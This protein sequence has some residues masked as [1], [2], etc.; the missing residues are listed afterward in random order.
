VFVDDVY[1]TIAREA[2]AELKVKGSRFIG[3]AYLAG[4]EAEALVK[5]E[6]VR[7]REHAATHHCFAWQ[8]GL[9]G[10]T[11]FKYSDAGEPSGTAG[12][13]I[14]DVIEGAGLTNT[15]IVVTR[16]FGG[17]KLGTGG[18]VH[19]YGNAAQAALKSAGVN[20]HYLTRTYR[21]VLDFSRYDSWLRQMAAM[22]AEIVESEFTDRVNLKVTIRRSRAGR[23]R[24]AF[25]EVTAGKGLCEEI[26]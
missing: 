8:I 18:L 4:D 25:R 9:E 22:E 17:T 24:D 12:R 21:L 13:P 14:Y 26:D 23:L 15:M 6:T 11:T 10:L 20:T 3:E 7:K 1:H 16:Y 2:R 5:L 19:A